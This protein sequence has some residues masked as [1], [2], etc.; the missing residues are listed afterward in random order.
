M[1][2]ESIATYRASLALVDDA[3]LAGAARQVVA[4]HGFRIVSNS[5]DA[6]AADAAHLRRV[7]RPAAARRHRP[8]E[9]CR[10]RRRAAGSRSRPSRARSAS[11][12]VEHGSRYHITAARRPALGRWRDA[13]QGRRARRL[14]ARPRALRRL[15]QQRLCAAR[16]PRRRPADHLGQR[17]DG[18]RHDLPHRRPL[19]RD[20]RAQRHLPGQPRPAIR[21]EDIADQY[22]REGLE[23]RGRSGAG[24]AQRADH[25]RHSRSP[26]RSADMQPGAY[27]ITAK[28]AGRERRILGRP[29]DAVVHRHRSRPDHGLRRRRRPRLRALARPR[30]SRSP[31]AKVRLVAVNN[32]ILGEATT[33]ADGRADLRAGPGPRRRRPGAAI[34][35]RRDRRRRLRLPRSVASPP[36]T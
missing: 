5:V 8:V 22:R 31:S 10:R 29:R 26:T 6:E 2:R 11:T 19:D 27:V 33:D 28:V 12:G 30:A 13:A 23:R 16:R 15:C 36:S 25:H 1:W 7:L 35:G 34:A 18:R 17:R 4:Q 32:E 21:A 9:L 20:R 14:R 24:R 3:E